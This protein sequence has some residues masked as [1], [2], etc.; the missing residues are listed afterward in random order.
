M[1]AKGEASVNKR[2]E[3]DGEETAHFSVVRKHSFSAA[4]MSGGLMCW[5][6][7]LQDDPFGFSF[8]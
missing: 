2:R 6:D 5:G 3:R 8:H 7:S 1:K 4:N